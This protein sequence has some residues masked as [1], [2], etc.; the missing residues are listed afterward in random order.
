MMDVYSSAQFYCVFRE[1]VGV[2]ATSNSP[3]IRNNALTQPDIYINIREEKGYNRK[4]KKS[5]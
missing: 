1:V 3:F 2:N 4:K 5:E